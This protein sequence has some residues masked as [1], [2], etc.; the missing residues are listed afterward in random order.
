MEKDLLTGE[1]LLSEE[2]LQTEEYPLLLDRVQ[3]MFIDVVLI[4]VMMFVFAALLDKYEHPPDWVRIVL[5]FGLWAVYEPLCTV[6]GCTLGQYIKKIRVRNYPDASKHINFFQAFVR[7]VLKTC[8]GWISFL[9]I[10]T[11]HE[12]RAIHDYV[13]GSVMVKAK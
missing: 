4:I 7:Y 1:D 13:A 6:L 9:T 8:L 5:F 12:K 2:D 3:S 10:N 11:N